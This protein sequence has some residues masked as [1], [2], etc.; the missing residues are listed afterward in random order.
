[1]AQPGDSQ[2]EAAADEQDGVGLREEGRADLE[3]QRRT[4]RVKR[5]AA[6]DEH[7]Q[8]GRG[9]HDAAKEAGSAPVVRQLLVGRCGQSHEQAK[10][11]AVADQPHGVGAGHVGQ[12]DAEKLDPGHAAEQRAQ[13]KSRQNAARVGNRP[14]EAFRHDTAAKK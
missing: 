9:Q 8:C 13:E 12:W 5:L 6:E 2:P 7:G 4:R 3:N 14:V 1:M 10:R 11:D